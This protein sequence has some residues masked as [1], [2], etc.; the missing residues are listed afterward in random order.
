MY[1]ILKDTSQPDVMCN[2]WLAPGS[3]N[4]NKMKAIKEHVCNNEDIWIQNL[5]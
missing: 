3:K 2:H 4:I 5:H 1:I